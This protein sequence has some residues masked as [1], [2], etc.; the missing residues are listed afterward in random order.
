MTELEIDADEGILLET[1]EASLVSDGDK[2]IDWLVLTDKNLYIVTKRKTGL[3]SSEQ[4]VR[5]IPLSSIKI[6]NGKPL[7]ALKDTDEYRHCLQ[8]QSSS[9]RDLIYFDGP[10]KRIA[11]NWLTEIYGLLGMEYAPEPTVVDSV[12][13]GIAGI[14]AGFK[15][16]FGDAAPS[17]PVA[18][19]QAIGN[20]VP[21]SGGV[22]YTE[23]AAQPISSAAPA[24]SYISCRNCGSTISTNCKFCPECGQ[25]ATGVPNYP[26]P[27]TRPI[28]QAQPDLSQR[29]IEYQGVVHKCPN[30]GGEVDPFDAVCDSCGYRISGRG[31]NA[32][33]QEFNR[34]LMAIEGT[35]KRRSLLRLSTDFLDV[36]DRQVISLINTF[37]IPNNVAELMEFMFMSAS[38][39]NPKYSKKGILSSS[40]TETP[41]GAI[42]NAWLS[43]M[44][45]VYKKAK[46]SFSDDPM[47]EQIQETYE[48][49]M[50][51]LKRL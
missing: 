13:S 35:R 15:Q 25:A 44:E 45:Q 3:F 18:A 46:M 12:F 6:V 31:A 17:A 28:Q 34:Q 5:S 37:P 30:C 40:Y 11:T 24:P 38:N 39:I 27:I 19:K 47:F 10:S 42:S 26:P 2:S 21:K 43:K 48:H 16:A 51:E 49:K 32:T 20:V 4:Q 33:V 36:T 9:G 14:A 50:R 41:E 22:P 7:V 23:G 8:I 29:R 1:D